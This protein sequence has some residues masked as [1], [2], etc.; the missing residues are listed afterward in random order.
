MLKRSINLHKKT[1]SSL[2]SKEENFIFENF[3][4]VSNS[5]K[6]GRDISSLKKYKNIENKQEKKYL[7]REFMKKK[8]KENCYI[9]LLYK[10]SKLIKSQILIGFA[11]VC[12]NLISYLVIDKKFRNQKNGTYLIKELQNKFSELEVR[13]EINNPKLKE[14]YTKKNNFKEN[15]FYEEPLTKEKFFVLKWSK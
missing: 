12:D 1:F 7:F 9:F 2:T 3:D 11:I 10:T 13:V 15:G 6:I 5:L 8:E 14:F 4:E